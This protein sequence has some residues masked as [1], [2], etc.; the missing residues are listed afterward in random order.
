[1][2]K[3]LIPFGLRHISQIKY[4]FFLRIVN[5]TRSNEGLRCRSNH[6]HSYSRLTSKIQK[7]PHCA[8]KNFPPPSALWIVPPQLLRFWPILQGI[9]LWFTVWIVWSPF[10][11][12]NFLFTYKLVLTFS[13]SHP[14]VHMLAPR[15]P[16][17]FYRPFFTSCGLDLFIWDWCLNETHFC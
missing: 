1:M 15:H 10:L 12:T 7:I 4:K 16:L 9:F 11:F 13:Y 14:H 6:S 17:R 5:W 2:I 3:C 8:S